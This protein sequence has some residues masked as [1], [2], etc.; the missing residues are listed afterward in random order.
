MSIKY[1][2]IF[3]VIAAFLPLAMLLLSVFRTGNIQEYTSVAPNSVMHELCEK[4]VVSLGYSMNPGL[5]I[6]VDSIT[7][8]MV[9]EILDIIY[10][11]VTLIPKLLKE[12]VENE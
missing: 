7:N 3:L 9:I 5:E 8:M 6:A 4:I 1:K 11:L 2:R 10:Q 12:G